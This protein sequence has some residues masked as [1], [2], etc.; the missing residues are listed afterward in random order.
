[1]GEQRE[2]ESLKTQNIS[3]S[4]C[5]I[6]Y[7]PEK[8]HC[9]SCHSLHLIFHPNKKQDLNSQSWWEEN[10]KIYE[11]SLHVL[12][13]KSFPGETPSCCSLSWKAKPVFFYMMILEGSANLILQCLQFT[14]CTFTPA[15]GHSHMHTGGFSY[16]LSKT[17][18][19]G[20]RKLQILNLIVKDFTGKL[21]LT[22]IPGVSV[23]ATSTPEVF[24]SHLYI[25]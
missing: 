22:S 13:E 11:N 5:Y 3:C 15:Y 20:C 2:Q 4:G 17:C 25:F 21:P 1:M 7:L 10:V 19:L 23:F 16:L 12:Q 6:L 18:F 14:H 24:L 8:E 9:H